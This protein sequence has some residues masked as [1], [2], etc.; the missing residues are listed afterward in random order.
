MK[1]VQSLIVAAWYLSSFGTH[2]KEG[3]LR[4][5][6]KDDGHSMRCRLTTIDSDEEYGC[7]EIVDGEE[8]SGFYHVVPPKD[9]IQEHRNEVMIGRLMVDITGATVEKG[10]ILLAADATFTVATDEQAHRHLQWL[11]TKSLGTRSLF[12]VRVSAPDSSHPKSLLQMQQ[13]IFRTNTTSFKTQYEGCSNGKLKWTN[14]GGADIMLSNPIAS[15]LKPANLV[16][17]AQQKLEALYGKPANQIAN[18]VF[19]CNPPNSITFTAVAGVDSWRVNS[20]A[21]ICTSM[22]T[23]M[24]EVRPSR[25]IWE[26]NQS[27]CF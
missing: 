15:Y 27:P 2:A 9:L 16:N 8:T 17:E 18:H 24:H 22:S 4:S 25:L 5:R 12:Y 21:S 7:T 10:E 3:F 6:A 19:F 1:V 20:H 23:V 13:I 14:G 11:T 26:V